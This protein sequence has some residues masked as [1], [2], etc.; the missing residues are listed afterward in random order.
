MGHRAVGHIRMDAQVGIDARTVLHAK[1][2]ETIGPVVGHQ[3]VHIHV[4]VVSNGIIVTS[5]ILIVTAFGKQVYAWR[6]VPVQTAHHGE[7]T[8]E[9]LESGSTVDVV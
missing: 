4:R 2:I 8:E 3:H 7:V 6:D 5:G 1:T 9:F